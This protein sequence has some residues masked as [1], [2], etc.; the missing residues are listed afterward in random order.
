MA[1]AYRSNSSVVPARSNGCFMILEAEL[2]GIY[3]YKY[4]VKRIRQSPDILVAPN[5]AL[6]FYSP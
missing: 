4:I 5:F 1:V 2:E 6:P 3:K